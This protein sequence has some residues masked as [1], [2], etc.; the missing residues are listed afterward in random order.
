LDRFTFKKKLFIPLF[1]KSRATKTSPTED[2][3]FLQLNCKVL[4]WSSD[5]ALKMEISA[6]LKSQQ[7]K[8][9]KVVAVLN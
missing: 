3:L 4:N 5:N 7:R 8:K 1:S 9:L 6:N 2:D